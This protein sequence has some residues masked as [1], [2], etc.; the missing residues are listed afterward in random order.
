MIYL[1]RV[2]QQ[3]QRHT[4]LNMGRCVLR[5]PFIDQYKKKQRFLSDLKSPYKR[6]IKLRS[7]GFV[8]NYYRQNYLY[9]GAA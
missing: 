3:Y 7:I 6:D 4:S 8:V 9:L 5:Q 2:S 1:E